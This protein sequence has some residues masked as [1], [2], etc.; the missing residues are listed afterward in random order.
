MTA[1]RTTNETRR[2]VM[3]MAHVRRRVD[4]A[5]FGKVESFAAY[6]R[7]AWATVK[8]EQAKA[9]EEARTAEMRETI[10]LPTPAAVRAS[11]EAGLQNHYGARGRYYGD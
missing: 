11:F 9:A 4:A 7:G 8:A 6:L 10:V 2:R 5:L 1:T 3:K